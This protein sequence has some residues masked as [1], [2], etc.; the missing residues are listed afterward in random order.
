MMKSATHPYYPL[1][2]ELPGYS[3]NTI[4]LTTLLLGFSTGASLILG[5]ALVFSRRYRTSI[6][7]LDQFLV[8]WFVLCK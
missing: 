4:G 3:E 1:D 2:L 5:T 8:L 7:G 6:S